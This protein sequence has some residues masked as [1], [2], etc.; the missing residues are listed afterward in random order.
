MNRLQLDA[1]S[2]LTVQPASDASSAVARLYFTDGTQAN[3]TLEQY[4]LPPTPPSEAFDVRFTTNRSV[5]SFDV[6]GTVRREIPISI[7]GVSGNVR[8]S[9]NLGA[10]RSST[11]ILVERKDGNIVAEHRLNGSGS[12]TVD[13]S[14]AVTLRAEDLPAI[15]ALDQNYPNPFNPATKISFSLA[16]RNTVTLRI[17]N[18]LG[19]TV[20]T[21][22]INQQME[23]GQH[24]VEVDAH[25]WVSGVY[26]YQMT[27]GSFKEVKKMVLLK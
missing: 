20:A 4:A 21:P 7:Q 23:R 6:G 24:S 25:E 16:E 3:E 9:W 11:F 14:H 19:Q 26:F 18:I 17:Y 27:A 1:F 10:E 13:A 5:E 22:V 2:S 15:Y 8:L 12:M